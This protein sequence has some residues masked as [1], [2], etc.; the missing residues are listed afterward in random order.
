MT[1]KDNYFE[2]HIEGS[3]AEFFLNLYVNNWN[4][5][6]FYPSKYQIFPNFVL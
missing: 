3:S 4:F 2:V 6:Y 1:Y 5:S